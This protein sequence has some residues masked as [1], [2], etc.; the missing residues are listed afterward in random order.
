MFSRNIEII[1]YLGIFRYEKNKKTASQGNRSEESKQH[2][3]KVRNKAFHV[4]E[5][6]QIQKKKLFYKKDMPNDDEHETLPKDFA[7]HEVGE[8]SRQSQKV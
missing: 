6:I 2:M 8:S 3:S 1:F 4:G 5:I 7:L